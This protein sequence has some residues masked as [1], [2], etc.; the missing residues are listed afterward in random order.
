MP[1]RS[2]PPRLL[3]VATD[4]NTTAQICET[5]EASGFTTLVLNRD[6]ALAQTY[7]EFCPHAIVI[8]IAKPGERGFDVLSF[9]Y[10][11]RSAA[12]VIVL[13]GMQD[14]YLKMAEHLGTAL[15]LN[16]VAVLPKPFLATSLEQVLS[17]TLRTLPS[18]SL[19]QSAG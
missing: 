7:A 8:D 9:L 4:A 19:R 17:T 13:S 3:V 18:I 10:T 15:A 16:I 12:R 11:Q 14:F 2:V 1:E 5:G 6:D